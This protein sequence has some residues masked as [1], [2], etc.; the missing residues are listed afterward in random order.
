M[1]LSR[2]PTGIY[3]MNDNKKYLDYGLV[4]LYCMSMTGSA[5]RKRKLLKEVW[6]DWEA[7]TIIERKMFHLKKRYRYLVSCSYRETILHDIYNGN[8]FPSLNPAKIFQFIYR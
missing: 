2:I 6:S 3:M 5:A 1:F 4:L 8:I 7:L